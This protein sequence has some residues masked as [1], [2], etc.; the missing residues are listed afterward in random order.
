MNSSPAASVTCAAEPSP[1]G[2]MIGR[3]FSKFARGGRCRGGVNAGKRPPRFGTQE[4][5]MLMT[6]KD[7]STLHESILDAIAD[8]CPSPE[9]LALILADV[10]T[11]WREIYANKAEEAWIDSQRFDAA[12][13]RKLKSMADAD[14]ARRLK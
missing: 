6:P 10:S 14:E 11:N 1:P 9:Q 8:Y 2:L 3:G 12:L 13:A 4:A 5:E 7:E